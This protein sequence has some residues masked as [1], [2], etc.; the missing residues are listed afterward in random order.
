MEDLNLFE[1]GEQLKATRSR[2]LG[3][4]GLGLALCKE[5]ATI[6]GTE[7]VFESEKNKGTR[8]SFTLP[9]GGAEK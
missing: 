9:K 8:V 7:L 1:I 4:A 6:H 2:K 3:G 5:I